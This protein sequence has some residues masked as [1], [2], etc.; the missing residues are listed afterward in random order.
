MPKLSCPCGFIHNLLLV[1][2]DGWITVQD[3]QYDNL[4]EI[5]VQLAE[6]GKIQKGVTDKLPSLLKA[7]N[8]L[9]GRAYECPE[10]DRIMWQKNR[11]KSFHLT[12][13]AA[14][15]YQSHCQQN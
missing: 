1:P 2:D 15:N 9:Y 4:V 11:T 14:F 6:L 3:K 7:K 10:C 8:V 12:A 13:K 5:E